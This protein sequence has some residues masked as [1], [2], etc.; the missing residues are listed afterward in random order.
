MRDDGMRLVTRNDYL[1]SF[2]YVHKSTYS[3]R[4][5]ACTVGTAPEEREFGSGSTLGKQSIVK[6]WIAEWRLKRLG[7]LITD[8]DKQLN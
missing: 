2:R 5:T 3:L 6:F 4:F 8:Y 7:D 1:F